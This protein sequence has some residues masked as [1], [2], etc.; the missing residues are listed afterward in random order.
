MLVEALPNPK[1]FAI[2]V[3]HGGTPVEKQRVMLIRST[4]IYNYTSA[5]ELCLNVVMCIHIDTCLK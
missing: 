4:E 5:Q 3:R 1:I 2:L